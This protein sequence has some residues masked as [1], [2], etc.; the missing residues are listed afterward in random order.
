MTASKS[1]FTE[2]VSFKSRA[3]SKTLGNNALPIP[4]N[5]ISPF[6]WPLIQMEEGGN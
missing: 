2:A 3:L 1:K 5:K 4:K 6:P